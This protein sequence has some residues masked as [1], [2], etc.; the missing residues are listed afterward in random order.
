MYGS[1]CVDEWTVKREHLVDTIKQKHKLAVLNAKNLKTHVFI[2]LCHMFIQLSIKIAP[3]TGSG[4]T[5]PSLV[6][7]Q[8]QDDLQLLDLGLLFL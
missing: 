7:T 4:D 2:P 6:A 8:S 1:M 3:K 5:F